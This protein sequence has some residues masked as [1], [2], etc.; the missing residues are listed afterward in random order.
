VSRLADYKVVSTF[1]GVAGVQGANDKPD[2]VSAAASFNAPHG[3]AMDSVNLYVT[4]MRN[5]TIRKIVK[6]TGKVS[7]LAGLAGHQ[8]HIVATGAAARFMYPYGI[9]SDG[10]SLFVTDVSQISKIDIATGA[11]TDFV[12]VLFDSGSR[13]GI[14][15]DARMSNPYGIVIVGPNLYVADTNNCTIRKIVIDTGEVSTFA[16]TA[17]VLG[18]ADDIGAAASFTF[19]V[20]ITSDGANLYVADGNRTIRKIVIETAAV[21]T[22]AGVAGVYG[23]NDGVGAAANFATP[24]GITSDG[25]SLFVTDTVN[26]NIR[27]IDIATAEVTTLAGTLGVAG[28]ADGAVM[29]A[30]FKN[31]TGI[32]TDGINL[33]VVDTDNNTIRKLSAE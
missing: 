15:T 12:G 7:T 18:N 31:P 3:I 20:G 26:S 27:K 9:A 29:A 24:F 32:V 17:G 30:S 2:E 6:A 28:H 5:Y 33:Y 8:D 14:G 16:G 25:Q 22:F 1:A 13:N 19:P 21:S 10:K 4:D 23:A 11:V